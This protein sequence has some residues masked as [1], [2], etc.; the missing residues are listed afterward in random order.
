MT[1]LAARIHAA[2]S[3]LADVAGASEEDLPEGMEV[4]PGYPFDAS[5]D[6]I[7]A[8]LQRWADRMH[9]AGL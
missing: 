6:E 4:L 9:D 5:L 3:A 8:T 1:P 2:A 7:V